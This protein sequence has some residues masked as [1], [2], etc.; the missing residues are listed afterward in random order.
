MHKPSSCDPNPPIKQYNAPPAPVK[1]VGAGLGE[2]LRDQRADILM[3]KFRVS[4]TGYFA[5]ID[6]STNP[7]NLCVENIPRN[8]IFGRGIKQPMTCITWNT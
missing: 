7:P 6:R 4:E 2:F 1:M 5:F 3:A 8:Q